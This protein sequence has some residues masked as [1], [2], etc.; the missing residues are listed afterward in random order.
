M[1]NNKF[2][3]FGIALIVFGALLL[4][5]KTDIL[6]IDFSQVIWAGVMVLGLGIVVQGFSR[7]KRGKVFWGTVLFLYSLYFF[8]HEFEFIEYYHHIFLPSSLI[9]F[10]IAFFMLFI[11]NVREWALIIPSVFFIG[12]GGAFLLSEFGYVDCDEVW[13]TMWSYW[14]VLLIAVGLG[15]LIKRRTPTQPPPPPATM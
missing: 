10:G 5:I 2:S 7:D 15:I 1:H 12:I 13:N 14:P 11:S 8:L 4:L 9:I 6:D 3:W